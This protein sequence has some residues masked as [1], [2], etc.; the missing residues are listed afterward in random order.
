[1]VAVEAAGI[2]EPFLTVEVKSKASGEI[3]RLHVD[4]GDD[5]QRGDLLAEVDPRDVRNDHNQA[6]ADLEVAEARLEIAEA[7]LR[8]SEE[9]LAAE[10]ITEQ[11]HEGRA[12]EFANAPWELDTGQRDFKNGYAYGVRYDK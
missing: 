5:V 6:Q 2:I 12:L 9:L 3:L 11:E 10:V 4:V 1:M 8:R 7:Q